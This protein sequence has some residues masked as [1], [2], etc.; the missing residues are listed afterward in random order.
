MQRCTRVTIATMLLFVTAATPVRAQITDREVRQAISKGVEFL[1]RQQDPA[2]GGWPEYSAH[3][4]GLSALCTL[5]LLNAGVEPSDPAI[6]RALTYLRSFDRPEMTYSVALRTMVFCAAEPHK[7]RLIIRRNVKWLEALQLTKGNRKGTWSYSDRQGQGDNSNTQFAMLALN[8]AERVGVKVNPATWRLALNHWQSSQKADGAW[9]Y[10]PDTENMTAPA[11]GSMT[12]AGIASAV[13]A[14]GRLGTGSARIRDG[15]VLCCGEGDR[16]GCVERGLSWLGRKFSVR[17]NPGD[18][19]W[20]LYYLYAV[21]RVGRLTGRRFIGEHDWYREGAEMLIREQDAFSGHWR[22]VGHAETNPLIGTSFALLFLSKGRRPVVM[23]KARFGV[24]GNWDHHP[25]G[26]PNLVRHIE[27]SWQ[28]ELTW[29]TIDLNVATEQ[30]LLETPVL[31]LSGQRSLELSAQQTDRLRNYVAQGGFIFAEACDGEG[32]RGKSFDRSFRA[33]LR[34]LFP[35]S[36]LRL[37]PPDHAVWFAD[38]K[39]NSKYLRPLYGIDACCRTSVVYC[40][41]NL[42]CFWELSAAGRESSLPEDVAEE[43]EAYVQIGRNVVAYATARELKEKLDQPSVLVRGGPSTDLSRGV[44]AIPKLRHTGG[45]DDA[46]NALANLLRFAADRVELR[47]RPEQQLLAAN[48][49]ELVN[50][51]VLFMHGRRS[52]QWT[53]QERQALSESISNGGFLFA[54]AICASEAFA[55]A[56]RREMETVFPGHKLERVP[57]NHPL[58]STDFGGFDLSRVTLND[59]SVRQDGERLVARQRRVAPLLE[60]VQVDGRLAVVFSPYDLSCALESNATLECK[61]YTKSDAAKMG[62]NIIL[63]ALQQ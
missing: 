43:V 23:A 2:R 49:T 11:T 44:L 1:K 29:Q 14:A 46:P 28:Q 20:L 22:G 32:C 59:P 10:I 52:F 9:G 48:S 16:S 50:Y 45:S 47:V 35:D 27:R 4:G 54:D 55:E 18:N 25:A 60:G 57:V 42:S 7:D 26:V 40:P 30:D 37:L 33:L 19:G 13:I 6:Q 58:F 53:Q 41:R 34:M 12:C 8:E 17:G 61:G 39:V 63:F 51:P 31:F 5:A 21:E 24:D 3:P 36:K 62:T 15:H 56:F 38:G